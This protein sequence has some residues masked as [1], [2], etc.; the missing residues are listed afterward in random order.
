MPLVIRSNVAGEGFGCLC[1]RRP[2]D[3]QLA[4]TPETPLFLDS[5]WT[6]IS[7]TEAHLKHAPELGTPQSLSIYRKFAGSLYQP[8]DPMGNK[9]GSGVHAPTLATEGRA[10]RLRRQASLQRRPARLGAAPA[11]RATAWWARDSR[12]PRRR[13]LVAAGP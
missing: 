13:V 2:K 11:L 4:F 1:K 8:E 12:D 10:W 7:S 5:E 3:M 9:A 6:R